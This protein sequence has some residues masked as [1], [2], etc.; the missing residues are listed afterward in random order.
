MVARY[1]HKKQ[2][3]SAVST[4]GTV[5]SDKCDV[6]HNRND[7]D[8]DEIANVENRN[9]ANATTIITDT[10]AQP[11][12]GICSNRSS[13]GGAKSMAAAAAAA[14][15]RSTTSA[16]IKS[17]N[18]P[19]PPSAALLEKLA[20]GKARER[21]SLSDAK[22]KLAASRMAVAAALPSA[23]TTPRGGQQQKSSTP[24]GNR[25]SSIIMSPRNNHTFTR[26]FS[27]SPRH[28]SKQQ[29]Q[30]LKPLLQSQSTVMTLK[31]QRERFLRIKQ[32]Q[33]VE[34]LGNRVVPSSPSSF[35]SVPAVDSLKH[36]HQTQKEEVKQ[37]L[38]SIQ[39][40]Q[41]VENQNKLHHFLMER[42]QAAPSSSTELLSTASEFTNTTAKQQL[43]MQ[44][45]YQDCEDSHFDNDL[46]S[47]GGEE[48]SIF[49][50][51][52]STQKQPLLHQ[53]PQQH[54]CQ[55]LEVSPNCVDGPYPINIT[56]ASSYSVGSNG[57]NLDFQFDGDN[58]NDG[59]LVGGDIIATVSDPPLQLS[60]SNQSV[61]SHVGGKTSRDATDIVGDD[62]DGGND[63]CNKRV[64][65][66]EIVE[67]KS[68]T[69]SEGRELLLVS[70]SLQIQSSVSDSECHIGNVAF[71]SDRFQDDKGNTPSTDSA[72]FHRRPIDDDADDFFAFKKYE[73]NEFMKDQSLM[74]DDYEK[75]P[76]YSTTE[77]VV[78]KDNDVFGDA[79]PEDS[80]SPTAW[81]AP[82]SEFAES[83]SDQWNAH[84][85]QSKSS[86]SEASGQNDGASTFVHQNSQQTKSEEQQIIP[87]E[88][89][90]ANMSLDGDAV[91]VDTNNEE[92]MVWNASDSTSENHDA[93]NEQQLQDE[94]NADRRISCEDRK[95]DSSE[96]GDNNIMVDWKSTTSS[97]A[98]VGFGGVLNSCQAS[99]TES[100]DDDDEVDVNDVFLLDDD[101]NDDELMS[102]TGS[103]ETVGTTTEFDP[104]SMFG[105]ELDGEDDVAE[106]P[107]STG[108]V[109]THPIST[110][111]V[112]HDTTN[113][114]A[115]T[116]ASYT[117]IPPMKD[118]PTGTES[119]GSWWQ[120]RHA[121]TQNS[122][123]NS[124]VQ[125]ALMK[126]VVFETFPSTDK[127]DE[128]VPEA[129]AGV[130]FG[131]V[132]VYQR[133]NNE[134]I[135]HPVDETGRN[136]DE[137][138]IFSGLE[139]P[140]TTKANDIL[141]APQLPPPSVNNA[142]PVF[143]RNTPVDEDVFSGVSVSSRQ[144][145]STSQFPRLREANAMKSLLDG[146]S[147]TVDSPSFQQP[148]PPPLHGGCAELQIKERCSDTH[149]TKEANETLKQSADLFSSNAGY[150][151]INFHKIEH[152]P[153][154][155]SVT[156]DIT[157]SVIF[158]GGDFRKLS[159]MKPLG[160]LE[161]T[162]ETFDP[163]ILVDRSAPDQPTSM[164]EKIEFPENLHDGLFVEITNPIRSE[165]QMTPPPGNGFSNLTSR[166]GSI[167]DLTPSASTTLPN[168]TLSHLKAQFL[169]KP[170]RQQD[171]ENMAAE[172]MSQS[173]CPDRKA[174]SEAVSKTKL[175]FLSQLSCGAFA[176]SS[177]AFCASGNCKRY[178]SMHLLLQPHCLQSSQFVPFCWSLTSRFTKYF[179]S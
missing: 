163:E 63:D 75:N 161:T 91:G 102:S 166:G 73:N 173:K 159:F 149:C 44:I 118:S 48:N 76:G 36:P 135:R 167:V 87:V 82:Q 155:A 72:S 61:G 47:R 97:T 27:T 26:S 43:R 20:P 74:Q 141:Q 171:A 22:R 123:V 150:G 104:L 103:E 96:Q 126:R 125:E 165:D 145:H 25:T 29:Q 151:V 81:G 40:I 24:K 162:V 130:N 64:V 170:I 66:K 46:A 68:S 33:P 62:C 119:L 70:S 112:E 53:A 175:A 177:F 59:E 143:V 128:S 23:P 115:T 83:S 85:S 106:A 92:L 100:R 179:L 13:G 120:S 11:R 142:T 58:S 2:L 15:S 157:S 32:C 28:Q 153:T 31:A 140:M 55:K 105:E 111:W 129:F 138:S 42:E 139:D 110:S 16:E 78:G 146:T 14:T 49:L 9:T 144:E 21:A 154:N 114:A 19:P 51:E 69:E 124:A 131:A 95:V 108:D 90:S 137:D 164:L 41:Q 93:A 34:A 80:F 71:G 52:E 107:A 37:L 57:D 121:L 113:A 99:C 178:S 39:P 54:Y 88:A 18:V 148:P 8:G 17:N 160:I 122:D 89:C 79:W 65:Q 174:V 147:T 136:D 169:T 45:M 7:G 156:S 5:G 127:H 98:Y 94:I 35:M 3:G 77:G 116:V 101:S 133:G 12:D 1:Q 152:S 67:S 50:S 134:P 4:I 6:K 176:S 10:T 56:H 132:G 38:P 109:A 168:G 172:D 30:Q 86:S 158:G 60:S 117:N 84:F